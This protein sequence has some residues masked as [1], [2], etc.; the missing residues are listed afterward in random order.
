MARFRVCTYILDAIVKGINSRRFQE[1]WGERRT[2]DGEGMSQAGRPSPFLG[3]FDLPFD[4]GFPE[5][6]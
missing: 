3:W 5:A 1:T 2:R 4:L 6:I